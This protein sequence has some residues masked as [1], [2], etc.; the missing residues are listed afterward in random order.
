MRKVLFNIINCT[1]G[2]E[3]EFNAVQV[4]HFPVYYVVIPAPPPTP[5]YSMVVM[6]HCICRFGENHS[7][8][9]SKEFY[10]NNKVTVMASTMGGPLDMLEESNGF[11]N[12]RKFG[13]QGIAWVIEA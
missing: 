8:V 4:P 5:K 11:N 2:F 1:H 10:N 7:K 9:T 12:I 13:R 6:V 3:H